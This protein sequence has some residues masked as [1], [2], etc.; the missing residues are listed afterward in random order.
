[1]YAIRSYYG[2]ILPES[3]D[4]QSG[5]FTGFDGQIW[6]VISIQAQA[7]KGKN[8]PLNRKP[9]EYLWTEWFTPEY[10]EET[11]AIQTAGDMRNW[12]ALYQQK[13]SPEGGSFF[14][15]EW[16]KFYD[17]LP[18]HLNR[19]ITHDDAVTEEAEG[20]D[21]DYTEIGDWGSYNFV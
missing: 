4:G 8:D 13:P 17:K 19:Y 16:F 9:G 3:W 15:R 14:K 21:P 2:R 5:D 1:M 11:K 10:W 20:E 7:E 18:A 6:K 12:S